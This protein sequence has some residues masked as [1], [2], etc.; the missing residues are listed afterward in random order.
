MKANKLLKNKSILLFDYD[1]TLVQTKA[2]KF[3]AIKHLGKEFYD[4]EL[5]SED[6]LE[7]WG[8]PFETVFTE[9]FGRFDSTEKI[10]TNY[11]SITNNFPMEAYPE[12][13]G[14]INTLIK[15]YQ[16]GILTASNRQVVLPDLIRLRFPTDSFI[17]IQTSD[18]TEFHKPDPRVFDYFLEKTNSK[19]EEIIY[20]GDSESD[21]LATKAA[22]ID[23]VLINRDDLD[24]DAI[25]IN[26]LDELV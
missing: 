18:D 14:A 19:K 11:Y 21:Y 12:T 20:I 10:V 22:G 2:A 23:F 3:N 1:D 17:L 26:S 25:K 15:N 9:L 5:S 7:Q 13:L 24:L 6:I 8:K 16:V 4:H